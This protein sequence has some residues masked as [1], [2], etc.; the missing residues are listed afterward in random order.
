MIRC[1]VFQKDPYHS[2]K[3]TLR[4]HEASFQMIQVFV[5]QNCSYVNY[6]LKNCLL[7]N[8]YNLLNS[9]GL[10]IDEVKI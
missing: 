5:K 6:T 8:I 2:E 7:S 3:D 4:W 10:F 9:K 1:S